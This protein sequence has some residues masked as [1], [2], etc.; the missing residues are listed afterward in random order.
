LSNVKVQ[1]RESKK[2]GIKKV[3][4]DSPS[5]EYSITSYAASRLQSGEVCT[6]FLDLRT[7]SGKIEVMINVVDDGPNGQNILGKGRRM[8]DCPEEMGSSNA[9]W[10]NVMAL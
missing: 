2:P 8:P 4:A 6:A 3:E 5:P 9:D 10:M 7:Y 1:Y